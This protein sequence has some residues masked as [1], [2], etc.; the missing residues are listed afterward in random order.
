[1]C[2]VEEIA[3]KAKGHV[4]LTANDKNHGLPENL[5][6]IEICFSL[7]STEDVFS[8]ISSVCK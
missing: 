4:V 3:K 2:A 7:P 1:M 5:E 6:T 8:H